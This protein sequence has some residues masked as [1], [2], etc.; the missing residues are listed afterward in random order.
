MRNTYTQLAM[1]YIV[2]ALVF[3]IYAYYEY[4]VQGELN[5]FYHSYI[6]DKEEAKE[7]AEETGKGT[8][9]EGS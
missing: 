8:E 7:H 3:F 4:K 6:P 1:F 9:T 2:C 5:I